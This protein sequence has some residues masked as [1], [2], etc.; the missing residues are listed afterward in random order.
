MALDGI[1]VAALTYELQEALVG[2][3]ISKIIQ[4]EPDALMLTCKGRDGN[5]VLL[6]SANASLPMVYLTDQKRQAPMTAPNFC[7]L[8]RKHIG[9]GKI[10]GVWQPSLERIIHIDIE[11]YDEMG[12]LRRK[13]LVIELMGKYSN[14]IFLGEDDLIIDSIKHISAMTSSVREV[15]PGR[16]Y[17]IPETQ[18][19][20]DPLH[21]DRDTF[22]SLVFDKPA[23]LSKAIYTSYTGIS[24]IMAEEVCARAGVDS[25][26][27]A[28]ALGENARLHLWNMF[29]LMMDEVQ[30]KDFSPVIFFDTKN[31]PVEFSALP[32][33]MYQDLQTKQYDSMSAVMQSYYALR[34]AVSRIRQKSSDLRRIVHTALERTS[35]KL[36]L[37]KK[38][39]ADTDK[40]D[41]Y[42]LY[43]ELLLTYTHD[44]IPGKRNVTVLNYYDNNELT[45]PLDPDLSAADNAKRYYEKYARLKRTAAATKEQIEQTEADLKQLL[46]IQTF[47]DMALQ[48]EDLIQ[49][50][51]E[52]VEAGY[53][54][55]KGPKVKQRIKSKPYH[56]R[57]RDGYDLYVGK[58]NYQNDELTFQEASGADWW[59][60]AKGAPGSHVI[61]KVRG[62]EKLPDHVFEDAARL[63]AYYSANRASGKAEIDY[64]EK[65]HV[66]KP[67]GAK[68]GFVVY[69]T[70]YSMVID[71]D[72]SHLTLVE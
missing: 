49:V 21:T 26:R 1:T 50:R 22:L 23:V 28:A 67:G 65:K 18:S 14:I 16:K 31:E 54:R 60:H 5:R 8:L 56:Y 44:V 64:V 62:T 42:K 6:L 15:L 39:M 51:A 48:E 4:P 41:K 46:S 69:Y 43:G 58:N 20:A 55:H 71:T 2:S 45:I 57:T 17:F 13:S 66:K 38:Q 70:N 37:Q 52:L 33:T 7:M 47:L 59:F 72:I 11:H 63:A 53:I 32:L 9:S 68:P 34:D 40:R 36:D 35:R 24:P 27:A 12:D 61:A 3:R 19:K 10:I 25:D 30:N 29:D